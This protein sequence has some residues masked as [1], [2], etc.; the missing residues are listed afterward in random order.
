MFDGEDEEDTELYAWDERVLHCHGTS[1]SLM[2]M[3]EAGELHPSSAGRKGVPQLAKL[4]TFDLHNGFLLPWVHAGPW[5]IV[6]DFWYFVLQ[7]YKGEC[8]SNVIP[9]GQHRKRI[10]EL[11]NHLV[12]TS[13][14]GRGYTDIIS[15][16][17]TW[18]MENWLNW[19]EVFAPAIAH[20]VMRDA[21]P[22]LV[23][24]TRL[25]LKR[26]SKH[27]WMLGETCNNMH[28]SLSPNLQ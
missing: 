16:K 9:K 2:E 4:D 26:N 18:V 11:G 1:S 10:A 21:I 6:K 13:D 23:G 12:L 15:S 27:V 24:M 8:P 17:G 7:D 28:R 3:V 25:R 5:G 14:M 19:L 22:A 20:E